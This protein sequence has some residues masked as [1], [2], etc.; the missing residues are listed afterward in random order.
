MT[1]WV[2]DCGH[3]HWG[4]VVVRKVVILQ[5]CNDQHPA[6]DQWP[7]N[8]PQ[9]TLCQSELCLSDSA[10]NVCVIHTLWYVTIQRISMIANGYAVYQY[11]A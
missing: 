4:Y 1:L 7:N 5:A 10:F 11:R 9:C 3:V 6:K 2:G 8:G